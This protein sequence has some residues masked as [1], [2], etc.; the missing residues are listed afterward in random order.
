M[1][2]SAVYDAQRP[3]TQANARITRPDVS[4]HLAGESTVKSLLIRAGRRSREEEQ[5]GGG[6]GRRR[7]SGGGESL[8]RDMPPLLIISFTQTLLNTDS[9]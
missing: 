2:Q 4:V 3:L 6:A 8:I 1:C 9:K 7:R 5:G